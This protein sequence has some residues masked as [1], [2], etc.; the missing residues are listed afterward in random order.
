MLPSK[1]KAEFEAL[2]E[3]ASILEAEAGL[4]KVAQLSG[5]RIIKLFRR[6]SLL[7]S[8]IWLPYGMR[9][10]RNADRLRALNIKTIEVES[11][12]NIPDLKRHGI[13]YPMLSGTSLRAALQDAPTQG[14]EELL[15]TFARFVAN[16]HKKAYISAH[17][18]WAMCS[19]S[20]TANWGSL[21]SLI[22]ISDANAV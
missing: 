21:M 15:K 12:F 14:T 22:C 4:I 13:I 3:G 16:L 9:F 1:T 11:V 17:C 7:S 8:Q 10:K 18:T 6:K 5:N 19:Y 20:K 2:I